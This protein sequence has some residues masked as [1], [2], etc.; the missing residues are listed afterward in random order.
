MTSNLKRALGLCVLVLFVVAGVAAY[1]LTRPPT[2]AVADA[3]IVLTATA[4]EDGGTEPQ[5]APATPVLKN[6]STDP[7]RLAVDFGYKV[8]GTAYAYRLG[9]SFTPDADKGTMDLG[10]PRGAAG[11]LDQFPVERHWSETRKA[12]LVAVSHDLKTITPAVPPT[13]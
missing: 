10:T 9:L 8:G 11:D 6:S 1:R 4:A 3:A 7:S 5:A 13:L 12:Y 2:V